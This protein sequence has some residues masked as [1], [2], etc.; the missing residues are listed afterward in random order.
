MY[1]FGQATDM[2]AFAPKNQYT[3]IVDDWSSYYV[4][5]TKA[6]LDGSWE[7]KDTWGG[8]AAKM[9]KMAPYTNLPD[10]IVKMAQETEAKITAGELLPFAGPITDQAGEVKVPEGQAA[11]EDMLLGMNWYVKGVDDTLPQ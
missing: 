10:D 6:V 8:F 11:P 5:R 4:A 9:V 3:A 1:G 2:I 7:S